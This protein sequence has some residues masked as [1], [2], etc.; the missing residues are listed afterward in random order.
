MPYIDEKSRNRLDAGS[1]PE[2]AGELN[3]VITRVIDNYLAD[4]GEL[5]Y[6]NINEVMGV[7]EC[8]KQEFYRRVAA[9]Y[10]D[11]KKLESGD[12]YSHLSEDT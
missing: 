5:R 1:S 6:A 11:K 2:T 9:P 12:V 10:E 7:L 4:K 3:Y 8:A